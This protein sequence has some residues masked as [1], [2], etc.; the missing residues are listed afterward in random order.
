[1]VVAAGYHNIVMLGIKITNIFDC[2]SG[3]TMVVK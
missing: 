3:K 1:M 2:L